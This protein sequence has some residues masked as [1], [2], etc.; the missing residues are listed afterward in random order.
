MKKHQRDVDL[1]DIRK[2]SK[3][4]RK[5]MRQRRKLNKILGGNAKGFFASAA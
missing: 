2:P 3:K 4:Q 1:E 5:I